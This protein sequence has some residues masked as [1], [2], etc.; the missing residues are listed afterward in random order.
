MAPMLR[1][2]EG[3]I[4]GPLHML[5]GGSGSLRRGGGGGEER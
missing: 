3:V 1:S 4:P 2:M 5:F